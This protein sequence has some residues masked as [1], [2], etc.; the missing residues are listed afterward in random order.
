MEHKKL[1]RVTIKVITVLIVTL[2]HNP[3]SILSTPISWDSPQKD[4]IARPKETNAHLI[5]I[6]NNNTKTEIIITN[7]TR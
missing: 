3:I 1:N 4:Y 7:I 2:F 5:F 6:A